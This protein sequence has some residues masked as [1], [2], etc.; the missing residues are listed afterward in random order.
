MFRKFLKVL[1]KADGKSKLDWQNYWVERSRPLWSDETKAFWTSLFSLY[2]VHFVI[3]RSILL[4]P[5]SEK[6]PSRAMQKKLLAIT[7]LKVT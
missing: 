5:R 7:A 4:L 6:S 3:L 1:P 2:L